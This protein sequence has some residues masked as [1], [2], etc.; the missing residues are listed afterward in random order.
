MFFSIFF[1]DTM[2]KFYFAPLNF[3]SFFLQKM[4]CLT[5]TLD[6]VAMKEAAVEDLV[7]VDETFFCSLLCVAKYYLPR[8]T[9]AVNLR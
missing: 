4:H 6:V 7:F 9:S 3:L 5:K 8:F 1:V 2:I